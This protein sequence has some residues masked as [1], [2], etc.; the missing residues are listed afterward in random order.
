MLIVQ[1][2]VG[3]ILARLLS[4]K[5]YGLV[6]L[7]MIF[8]SISAAITDGGFEKSLINKKD[9]TVVQ[10]NTV[11]Y[12]NI[13]LGLFMTAAIIVLAPYIA[14]FFN[15]PQLTPVLRTVSIGILINAAGQTPSALLRKDLRFKKISYAH[16]V[17]SIIGGIA[18]LVLAYKG[19]G[20]WALV[21]STLASQI[22]MLVGYLLYS[23]WHPQLV[24]SYKAVKPMLSYGINILLSSIVFFTIQQFNYLIIG[25]FYN[26]TDLGLY[27][28]GGRFPELAISIIEGVI[29]KMAFPLF[30]KV[31]DED[32]QINNMLE[33][34][35]N[36]LAFITFP[37]LTLL[38]VNAKDVTLVLFTEKWSGSIIYL[39]IFCFVKIFYPF[40]I[41]Y[42]E[43]LLAK[44]H[45]RLSAKIL[46]LFSVGEIVLVLL[47]AKLGII[48][49][50]ISTLLSAVL[51]YITYIKVVS[52]T[53]KI[54]F[55]DQIKWVQT[56]VLIS[57]LVIVASL[58]VNQALANLNIALYLKLI[59]K[60]FTG[61]VCYLVFS[62]LFKINEVSY[63]KAAYEGIIKR[64][65]RTVTA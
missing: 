47:T 4:P 31:K 1:F 15:E 10:I 23:S 44:G 40:I 8:S 60:V 16:I 58:L 32:S 27:H 34:V 9:L 51:Q 22:V 25:K 28:R 19:F 5:D 49:V 3:I 35:I 48:Y 29:L 63:F 2:I 64:F 38:F 33:K 14:S 21:Y 62:F 43:I 42:K 26:E 36:V 18:G 59:I 56:Y 6:A 17:G 7:T 50:L 57:I 53:I 61:L 41:V 12:I 54:S 11:F 24:F 39:E 55:W 13:L 46:T 45:S 52:N 20:V 30:S 37:V 65:S